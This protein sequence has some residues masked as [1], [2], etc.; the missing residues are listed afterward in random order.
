MNHRIGNTD[1]VGSEFN[2]ERRRI[3]RAMTSQATAWFVSQRRG[4]AGLRMNG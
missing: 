4:S 1:V 3:S 2:E